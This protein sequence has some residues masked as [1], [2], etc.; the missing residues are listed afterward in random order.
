MSIDGASV[1]VCPACGHG[2][3]YN[4][5]GCPECGSQLRESKEA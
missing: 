3:D 1:Y 2:F 4:I 5:D